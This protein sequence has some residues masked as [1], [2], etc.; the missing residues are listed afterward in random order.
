M[1]QPLAEPF[2]R[3]LVH[4]AIGCLDWPQTKVVCPPHHFLV[5]AGDL[6]L[7]VEPG[8]LQAGQAADFLAEPRNPR[9][10]RERTEERTARLLGIAPPA[11]PCCFP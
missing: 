9:L 1:T 8:P 2:H 6:T 7:L 4:A 5:E 3:V 10:R 11:R